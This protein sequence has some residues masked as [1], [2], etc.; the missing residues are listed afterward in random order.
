MPWDMKDYP[1]S[2][3]NFDSLLRK[4][5]IEIANALL[6][7]G[8]EDDRAIPIAISQAKEWVNNAS[9]EEKEAF[10]KEKSLKKSDKHDTS[11]S[12]PKLLDNAVEVFYEDDHWVVKTKEAKRASDTFDKKSDAVDRAHEIA[13]N[14]DSEVIIYKKDGSRQK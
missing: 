10:D 6:A 5:T 11:S 8:Y 7:N 3:K 1:A 12:N 13:E 2:L 9:K 14:K 4:K